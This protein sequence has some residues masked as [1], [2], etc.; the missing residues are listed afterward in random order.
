GPAPGRVTNNRPLRG[1]K[2]TLYEGGV[3]VPAFASWQ[4]KIKPGT[5]VQAPLHIVDWYPTLL[6]LAGASLEQ[7]L[8]LDGKD[9]W[10]TI[11]K[12]KKA[13][14]QLYNLADDPGEKKDLAA[15][16]PDKVKQLRA[17]YDKLARQAVAPKVGPKPADFR[18]PKV[19]GEE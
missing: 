5:V 10:P 13:G 16:R 14:V 3:R 12:G 11:T 4:G 19:W 2:A 18:A 1:A 17:L 15:A 7:K 9:A 8:P 6:R